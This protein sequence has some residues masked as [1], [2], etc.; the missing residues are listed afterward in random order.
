MLAG[1]TVRAKSCTMYIASA[2]CDKP[3]L[4]PVTFTSTFPADA[5]VQD[6]VELPEPATLVGLAVHDVLLVAKLTRPVKPLR[7]VI[8]IVD[9]PAEPARTVTEVGLDVTV[10]SWTL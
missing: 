6:R 5:K 8:V 10:K 2:E 4:V 7:E 3:L 9:V 1:L